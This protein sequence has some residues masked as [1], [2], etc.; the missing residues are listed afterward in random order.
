MLVH[1]EARK[2]PFLLLQHAGGGNGS[3]GDNSAIV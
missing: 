2:M 1:N 3:G